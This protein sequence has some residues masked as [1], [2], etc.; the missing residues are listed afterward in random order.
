VPR[1]GA[2]PRWASAVSFQ[3][4]QPFEKLTVF[5]NLLV[6]ASFGRGASEAEVSRPAPTS[7]HGPG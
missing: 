5:E 4:P 3:I 1:D 6:A 7:S 2:L